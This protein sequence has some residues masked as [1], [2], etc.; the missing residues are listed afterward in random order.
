MCRSQ[1]RLCYVPLLEG[2]R[3]PQTAY[4]QIS[5][6][7]LR[8]YDFCLG[9]SQPLMSTGALPVLW[10]FSLGNVRLWCPQPQALFY[11]FHYGPLSGL[12]RVSQST[13][14]P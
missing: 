7:S 3:S 11:S 6:C 9:L 5:A 10:F 8:Y 14:P 12:K 13:H 1:G 2:G 4:R